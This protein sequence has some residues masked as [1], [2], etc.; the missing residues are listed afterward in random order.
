MTRLSGVLALAASLLIASCATGRPNLRPRPP[1]A[2]PEPDL[3]ALLPLLA[4][5]P[6]TSLHGARIDPELAALRDADQE[7]RRDGSAPADVMRRDAERLARLDV[8]VR[9]GRVR[10]PADH[11]AAALLYQHGGDAGAY[12]RAHRHA[13]QG[14]TEARNDRGLRRL[15]AATLD[16]WL[17][18]Q[19]RPQVFGTQSSKEGDAPWTQEPFDRDAVTDAQRAAAGVPGLEAQARRLAELAQADLRAL[20]ARFELPPPAATTGEVPDLWST[21][22]HLWEA[23]EVEAGGED[24][25]AVL[26]PSEEPFPADSPVHLTGRDWCFMALEGSGRVTRLDG[27]TITLNYAGQ[28]AVAVPCERWLG[29]R[30]RSQGSV[31]FGLAGGPYGDGVQS[32]RLVPYRTIAVDKNQE[33]IP[34]GTAVFVPAAVGDAFTHEGVDYTHDGWFF[35]ADT[36]GAITGRHIDTFTGTATESQLDHVRDSPKAERFEARTVA[37][38][39]P[40][41][42]VLRALHAE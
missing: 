41:A 12:A 19:G 7:D 32:R 27:S 40:V 38:D 13:L 24:V 20:A 1:A 31:R 18:S 28:T 9:A 22:Y 26:D 36:G 6:V 3:G 34:Y 30:W 14:L 4:G 5:D 8:L 10:T 2:A 35:A 42:A 23:A 39:D 25:F 16:R 17:Q 15:A 11:H 33:T 37:P 21:H 29:E